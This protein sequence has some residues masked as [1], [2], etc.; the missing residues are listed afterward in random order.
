MEKGVEKGVEIGEEIGREEGERLKA[1]EI[2]RKM[3]SK[4]MPIEDIIEM[5]GL[6]ARQI[7]DILDL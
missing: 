3:L 7:D 6:N 5:T 1:I 4:K 2:A